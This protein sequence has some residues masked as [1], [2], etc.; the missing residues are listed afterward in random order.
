MHLMREEVERKP[1]HMHGELGAVGDRNGDIVEFGLN[2]RES[3]DLT[4]AKGDKYVL[5]SHPPFTDPY[6][7]SASEPDHLGA[8]ETYLSYGNKTKEYL[9]NGKDVFHIPPDSMHLI[10]LHPDPR[11]ERI[12]GEFPVAFTLPEPQLPARPFANHE[13][14]ASFKENWAPPVGWKPPEDYPRG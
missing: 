11:M 9:T 4:V 14:P 5:H 12:L 13:A 7:S 6:A 10:R 3:V 8:A 1:F 2:P